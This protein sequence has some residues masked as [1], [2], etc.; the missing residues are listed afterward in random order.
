MEYVKHCYKTHLSKEEISEIMSKYKS[1]V[2]GSGIYGEAKGNH[3]TIYYQPQTCRNLFT[4]VF[5][6][7]LTKC[8]DGTIIKGFFSIGAFVKAFWII[9]RLFIVS[10]FFAV[11]FSVA[12]NGVLSSS[13]HFL[14]FPLI[15]FVL[16]YM[17]SRTGILWGESENV[18]ILRFIED[19]LNG[20]RQ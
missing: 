8:D 3:L 17:V 14:F 1:N 12:F 6:G 16:S 5:E 9:W 15:M 10:A 11:L 18:S 13:L 4:P 7:T 20:Q 2:S 19:K